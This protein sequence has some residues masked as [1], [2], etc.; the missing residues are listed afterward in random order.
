M[1]GPFYFLAAKPRAL[2]WQEGL[3][4]VDMFDP[5]DRGTSLYYQVIPLFSGLLGLTK[6]GVHSKSKIG[7][8]TWQR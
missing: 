5:F 7:L 6:S 3:E 1:L 4:L 8:M 2:E